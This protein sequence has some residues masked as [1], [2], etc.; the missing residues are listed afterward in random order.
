MCEDGEMHYI[1]RLLVA[2]PVKGYLELIRDEK[3]PDSSV[4]RC[5]GGNFC[6]LTSAKTKITEMLPEKQIH[7]A[8]ISVLQV[9][10]NHLATLMSDSMGPGKAVA[11][12]SVILRCS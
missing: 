3:A 6:W 11:K 8:Q 2:S 4:Q 12:S 10:C 1:C 9:H 5:I 7:H